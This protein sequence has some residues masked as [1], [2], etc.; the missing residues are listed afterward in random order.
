MMFYLKK[1]HIFT[2]K[3]VLHVKD[4]NVHQ[5]PAGIQQGVSAALNVRTVKLGP[6]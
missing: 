5:S 2:R 3:E 1:N 4:N 6:D